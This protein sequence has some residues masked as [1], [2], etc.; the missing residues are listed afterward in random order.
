MLPVYHTGEHTTMNKGAR[1]RFSR[2]FHRKTCTQIQETKT[3]EKR[4]TNLTCRFPPSRRLDDQ[5]FASA[6]EEGPRCVGTSACRNFLG[7]AN[8]IL[9]RYIGMAGWPCCFFQ[10][11]QIDSRVSRQAV[12]GLLQI[13]GGHLGQTPGAR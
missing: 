6:V 1:G 4:S 7:T 11:S 8:T 13:Q 9:E 12:R 10:A 2:F 5:Y 3:I